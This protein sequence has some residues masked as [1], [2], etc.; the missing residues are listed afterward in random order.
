ML[1]AG[2]LAVNNGTIQLCTASHNGGAVHI[3]SSELSLEYGSFTGNRAASG[4]ALYFVSRGLTTLMGVNIRI[5]TFVGN[6][7]PGTI[8]TYIYIYTYTHTHIYIYIYI[9]IHI[10]IYIYI[11]IYIDR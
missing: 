4:G 10:H 1:T 11:Y 2:I 7:Q 9:H 3:T 5:S 8:Y 6:A